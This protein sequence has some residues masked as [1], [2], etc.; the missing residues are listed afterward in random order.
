MEEEKKE[1]ELK[2]KK[3]E[4]DMAQV[5]E[6]KVREKMQK[7]KDSEAEVSLF[8]NLLFFLPC[9]LKRHK[10]H[11]N[12]YYYYYFV[13]TLL[14]ITVF[15]TIMLFLQL[16]KRHEAAL[17]TLESQ[18]LDLEERRAKFEKEKAAFEM[19][20]REMEDMQRRA[21]TMEI[22]ARE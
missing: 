16:Q 13:M 18:K 12:Y 11:Y 21:S 19:V 6:I 20:T 10:T 4:Q 2:M 15:M 3:M 9:Y 5:F 8:I 14:L 17:K 1:H 7:L 22:S